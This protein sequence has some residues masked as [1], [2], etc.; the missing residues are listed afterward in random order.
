MRLSATAG[1]VTAPFDPGALLR[2]LIVFD[3]LVVESSSL[4]EI[5]LMVRWFGYDD[6]MAL[7]RSGRISSR[8][9]AGVRPMLLKYELM[10]P[11]VGISLDRM[12]ATHDP[13]PN[14]RIT[15]C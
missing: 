6:T 14:Q 9:I 4:Q 2:G 11:R 8:S 12:H 10:F 3:H 1:G 5:P 7:L 15:A 13:N